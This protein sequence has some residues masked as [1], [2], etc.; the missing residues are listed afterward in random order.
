M[1]VLARHALVGTG[2]QEAIDAPRVHVR[3]LDDGSVRAEVEQD[4]ELEEA[5]AQ[6]GLPTV[7]HPRG[8]MF[9]GGVGAAHRGADGSLGAA[10]DARR[11][12]ATGTA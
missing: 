4:E 2:L 9:F 10:A 7:V 12:A 5:A 8:S 11:A 3:V 1:Q 6:A